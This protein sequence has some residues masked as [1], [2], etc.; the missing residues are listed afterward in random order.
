M[1]DARKRKWAALLDV[2]AQEYEKEI[3]VGSIDHHRLQ[4]R[5]RGQTPYGSQN[6]DDSTSTSM[7]IDGSSGEGVSDDNS[8]TSLSD[9]EDVVEMGSSR[10]RGSQQQ[11]MVIPTPTKRIIYNDYEDLDDY[12]SPSTIDSD[13]EYQPSII[14]NCTNSPP[15]SA[16]RKGK[17]TKKTGKRPAVNTARFLSTATQ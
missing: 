14:S 8:L 15:R 17:G 5:T 16:K 9:L 12:E 6:E 3:G 1:E 2:V 4:R 7:T 11:P 13:S 10:N